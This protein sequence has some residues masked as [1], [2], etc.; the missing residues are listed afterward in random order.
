MGSRGLCVLV[1]LVLLG[2]PWVAAAPAAVA[3]DGIA[4]AGIAASGVSDVTDQNCEVADGG[5]WACLRMPLSPEDVDGSLLSRSEMQ[6]VTDT[7]GTQTGYLYPDVAPYFQAM[8]DAY[9]NDPETRGTS[10]SF[11]GTYR[12]YE[13]QLKAYNHF[14]TTGQNLAGREVA[15]I[16]HPDNSMHPK[17]YAIDFAG[18]DLTMTSIQYQWLA[19]NGARF[20]FRSIDSEPWHWQFDPS[21]LK[22]TRLGRPEAPPPDRD[23][24]YEAPR[25]PVAS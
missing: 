14:I 1:A 23:R 19:A 24:Q 15:N 12:S 25:G 13:T 4:V 3:A 20:G 5:P 16:A 8:I 10:L 7:T 11:W 17:G 18:I 9:A 2:A 6:P 21:L 22:L